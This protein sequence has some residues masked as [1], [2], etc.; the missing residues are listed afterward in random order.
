M[1]DIAREFGYRITMFHHS[2]EAYKVADVLAREGVCSA[3]WANWWGFKMESLDGIEENAG[4]L[5][6]AGAC[7]VIHSDDENL[8]Q[9]LNQEAAAALSAARRGGYQISEEE[10]IKWITSN[11]AK[12]MGILDQTG[13]LEAGKRADVVLWS[14]DPFSIYAQADQVWIDGALTWDR[15]DPRFQPRSDFQLGMGIR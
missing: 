13:T 4:M 3:T 6:A 11:P 7:A 15:R 1:L 9:R 10:A 8:T 12:A 14:A 5:H 2:S